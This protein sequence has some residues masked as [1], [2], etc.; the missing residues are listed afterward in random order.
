MT[1]IWYESK[2][3]FVSFD[4]T[5]EEVLRPHFAPGSLSAKLYNVIQWLSQVLFNDLKYITF[6]GIEHLY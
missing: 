5:D 3:L 1:P 4:Y 2:V 6:E